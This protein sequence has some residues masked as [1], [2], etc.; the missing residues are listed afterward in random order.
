MTE[1]E[2]PRQTQTYVRRLKRRARQ[3]RV[4]FITPPSS[5]GEFSVSSELQP[6]A[7][8]VSFGGP[9]CAIATETK[10]VA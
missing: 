5:E 8:N 9:E 10:R 7:A 2:P 1:T 6:N 4:G 3:L